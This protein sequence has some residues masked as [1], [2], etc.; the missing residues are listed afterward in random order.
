M[1]VHAGRDRLA[2]QQGL[3]ELGRWSGARQGRHGP[4]PLPRTPPFH[5]HHRDRRHRAGRRPTGGEI[6]EGRWGEP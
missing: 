5:A 4:A 2:H 3:P 1:Q 6:S